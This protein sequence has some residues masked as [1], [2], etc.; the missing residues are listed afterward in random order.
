[1]RDAVIHWQR[2]ADAQVA[3]TPVIEEAAAEF[4]AMLDVWRAGGAQ[5]PGLSSDGWTAGQLAVEAGEDAALAA[6]L[7]KVLRAPSAAVS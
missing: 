5:V 2:W 6:L 7:P 4:N 3:A 1:L